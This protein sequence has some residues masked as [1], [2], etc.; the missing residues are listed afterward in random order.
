M[1]S[2][3]FFTA[4][5]L[6]EATCGNWLNGIVPAGEFTL[7]TDS[8]TIQAGECFIPIA[9]ER[10]NGHDFLDK[11]PPGTVALTHQKV[12]SKLD[13]P[14]LQVQDTTL[15]YQ[16]LARFHRQRMKQLKICAVTGSVGK[17]SVKEMLRAIFTEAAGAE[18]VLYTLGNTNN[19]IGVPQNLLR[20]TDNIRYAVIEMGTNHHGEIAPL[21]LCALPDAAIIN[22]IAPCH[23]ENLGDLNG[24]AKEKSHVFDGMP[25]SGI[26]IY[27]DT[28]A[29]RD[30]IAQ[31]AQKYINISFGKSASADVSAEY[32]QGSLNG[33]EVRLFFRKSGEQH[34][35]TWELAGEHQ[36]V[37]ASAA[38]A[39]AQALGIAPEVIAR[40]LS[41]T[42][43]PGKRMNSV[44]I[45][46]C[47][48]INDAY[49]ANP[50][51]MKSSL[52]CIKGNLT[53]DQPLLLVLGDMLELG[54]DELRYHAEILD[55]VQQ[56]FAGFS[57]CRLF[58]LGS[59]FAQAAQMQSNRT[60]STEVF[61]TLEELQSALQR[62]PKNGFTVF[63]KS[64]NSIGL[65][66][67]E[68][69]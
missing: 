51:S 53:S 47:I 32:L 50:Q 2:Q 26:A 34:T 57:A 46:N 60:I 55:F 20:L 31:A 22:T 62:I 41:R 44:K 7:N 14:L 9:G 36:A 61:S 37:N 19:Q 18:A 33:S 17:T 3:A 11:L 4:T 54:E 39:A 16:A 10:F 8:R 12:S 48:W 66:K 35:F 5:E 65:S 63:L 64:S 52:E 59:R 15:A 25:E 43:L 27:P 58:L 49:N 13:L 21:S 23:L 29:G 68:P 45:N 40:G 38:A 67:V 28:C 69:C 6:A 42:E 30:I 1:S 24:V 56:N